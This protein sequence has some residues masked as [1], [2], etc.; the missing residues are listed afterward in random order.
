[1]LLKYNSSIALLVLNVV[2]NTSSSPEDVRL[3][4]KELSSKYG[5]P[6]EEYQVITEDGYILTL[7]RLPGRSKTPVLLMHGIFSTSDSWILRGNASLPVILADKHHDVWIGNC[8]GNFYS[9]K[10]LYLNPNSKKF[11]NFTFHEIGLY[12]LSAIIDKVLE[13]TGAKKINAIGH[14]LGNTI[15]YVLGSMREEYNEKIN[16]MIALAPICF[17]HNVP[18]P[19]RYILGLRPF[20]EEIDNQKY[21]DIAEI[22]GPGAIKSLLNL[23]CSKPDLGYRICVEGILFPLTGFHKEE[24]GPDFLP[25]L[26]SHFP[27]SSSLKNLL[28][29]AQVFDRRQFS[30]YDY[31]FKRNLLLYNSTKPPMYDLKKVSM[32]VAL[33]AAQ[34]DR[35]SSLKD[36]A[37]LRRKLANI[38]S[39]FVMPSHNFNHVDYIWGEHAS[40]YLYP[41]LLSLL[42]KYS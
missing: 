22:F 37:I 18:A 36:V 1:M 39:D 5:H 42:D 2:I 25:V 17:L 13:T 26:T 10:H 38:V 29:L 16:V 33:I 12:D 20:V 31:K 3:F 8:R 19:V 7:H 41:Y 27:S 34:N 35:L 6:S 14:S 30:Q 23:I 9:R 4:F 28:H 11:W 24:L 40:L 15:F 32:P 21:L